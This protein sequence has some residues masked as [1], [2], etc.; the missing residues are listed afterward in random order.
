VELPGTEE[1]L[2][3]QPTGRPADWPDASSVKDV[4]DEDTVTME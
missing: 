1:T 3:V 2:A 4:E